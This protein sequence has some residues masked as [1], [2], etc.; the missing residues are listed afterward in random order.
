MTPHPRRGNGAA[1]HGSAAIEA[2]IVV[3][4]FVLFVA[5]I[6]V[7]GRIAVAHQAVAQ[8]AAQAARA[9]SIARTQPAADT[10]G[11]ASATATLT[12]QGLHCL[13]RQVSLDTSGFARPVGTPATITATVS[14]RIDLSD[15]ALPGVPGALTIT[16]TM[17]SP[18]DTYRER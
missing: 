9:A 4:A 13:T 16:E 6:I 3:P 5:M 12:S 2:V 10:D 8:A 15:A 7:G 1:E 14:C 17:T 18:L 11:L